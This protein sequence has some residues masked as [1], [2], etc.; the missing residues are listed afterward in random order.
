[1]LENTLKEVNSAEQFSSCILT[2][3]IVKTLSQKNPKWLKGNTEVLSKIM[4]KL[5]LELSKYD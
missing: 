3:R 2:L 1:M 4:E 5:N